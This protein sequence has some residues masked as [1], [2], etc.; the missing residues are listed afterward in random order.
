MA[1]WLS[2]SGAADVAYGWSDTSYFGDLFGK[3]KTE[4][5]TTLK[6]KY[7][8]AGVKLLV[9]AFGATD[10]PTKLNPVET[11]NRL[12]EFVIDN[13]FDGVD[14]DYEDNGAMEMGTGVPWLISF[15]IQLRQRLPRPY[16]ICH[17]P[18]APYFYEKRYP[19]EGYIG[20][21]KEVGHMIDFYTI[22]FYNQESSRY[23]TYE[24]LFKASTGWAPGTSVKELIEKGI[25]A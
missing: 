16:V 25:P 9:S 20:V 2:G 4:I 18:Q 17:A 21:N 23:D 15:T 7:S 8:G 14:I 6:K 10:Y 1:F 5:Q 24:T 3:T 12:A 19:H 11:A 22:Q 13:K